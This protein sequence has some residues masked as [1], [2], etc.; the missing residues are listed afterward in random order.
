MSFK[1][2]S[3]IYFSK[4]FDGN[5][6]V[7]TSKKNIK[8]FTEYGIHSLGCDRLNWHGSNNSL[9]NYKS[10]LYIEDEKTHNWYSCLANRY[11][12]ALSYNIPSFFDSS[13]ISTIEKSG[14]PIDKFFIVDS[15]EELREKLKML[16]DYQYD[17][18]KEKELAKKEKKETLDVIKEIVE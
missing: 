13:C 18:N 4:Y 8:K 10:S 9:F 7:S 2:G 14:Y 3:E 16:D 17:L 11:Y 1:A 6:S 5:F 15:R 12:E